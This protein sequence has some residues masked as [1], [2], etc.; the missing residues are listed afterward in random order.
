M[1]VSISIN[2][3]SKSNAIL[4]PEVVQGLMQKKIAKN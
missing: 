2:A 1:G 4:S 3:K